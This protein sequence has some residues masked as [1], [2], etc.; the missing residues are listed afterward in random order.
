MRFL[1]GVL[2]AM[3]K[4]RQ[5]PAAWRAA[6]RLFCWLPVFA[7]ERVC[8]AST[9]HRCHRRQLLPATH[10]CPTAARLPK[11]RHQIGSILWR[12]PAGLLWASCVHHRSL[13]AG[14]FPTEIESHQR[15]GA[16]RIETQIAV[17][18]RPAECGRD[19]RSPWLPPTLRSPADSLDRC[20][21]R[22]AALSEGLTRA[23]SRECGH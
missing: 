20:A 6:N 22:P 8:P 4:H 21:P 9:R 2:Q 23:A 5:P 12:S 1:S 11:P 10:P 18:Y 15:V 17:P 14:T 19:R 16:P 13:P 7:R 3:R